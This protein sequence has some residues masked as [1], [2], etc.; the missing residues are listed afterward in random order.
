MQLAKGLLFHYVMDPFFV[1]L[2]AFFMKTAVFCFDKFHFLLEVVDMTEQKCFLYPD[3]L[4][5]EDSI[6]P[7]TPK[8]ISRGA[9]TVSHILSS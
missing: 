9:I 5:L 3:L 7:R 6:T 2:A 8:V 4:Y 1:V